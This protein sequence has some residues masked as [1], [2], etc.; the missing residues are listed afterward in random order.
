MLLIVRS[1]IGHAEALSEKEPSSQRS[2]ARALALLWA[3]HDELES[4]VH[5]QFGAAGRFA[6]AEESEVAPGHASPDVT[7]VIRANQPIK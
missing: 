5:R 3:A 7:E 2:Y 6:E 1:T 4:S